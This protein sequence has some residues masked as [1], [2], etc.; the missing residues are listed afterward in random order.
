MKK[1]LTLLIAST[2]ILLASCSALDS[3]RTLS[4]EDALTEVE[5]YYKKI[6]P[7]QSELKKDISNTSL[8]QVEELP[9]I[10]KT[11][12]FKVEGQGK[13]NAEIFVST[14]KSG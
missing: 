14:E 1:A 9:D 11:Y 7:T 8:N 13:I 2:S 3:N 6:S 5:A 4:K 10:E 12:P